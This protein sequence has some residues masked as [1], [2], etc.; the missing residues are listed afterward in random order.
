[1]HSIAPV[2]PILVFLALWGVFHKIQQSWR[3]GFLSAALLWG[4]LL[5]II[6]EILSLF[7]LITF[8]AICGTWGLCLALALVWWIKT[9]VR[10]ENPLKRF[11]S[12]GM[13]IFELLLL[14]GIAVIAGIVALIAWVAP[15]NTVDALT[16]HMSRV[17]HWTQDQSIAFYPTHILRQLYL[18]P[19]SE[20]AILHFQ[21]LSASDRLANFV[22]WFSMVGSAIGLSLIAKRFGADLRGQVFS[23]VISTTIPIGILQGS[24]T[25]NDHAVAFWLVCFIYWMLALKA[26]CNYSSALAS[27]A[28]LGLAALTKGTA[29][30]YALPFVLWLGSSI[31]KTCR[32]KWFQIIGIIA[33]A[34]LALNLGYYIRNYELFSSPLGIQQETPLGHYTITYKLSNDV[35]SIPELTSNVVRNAAMNIGTPIKTV[36]LFLEQAVYLLHKVIG[37]SANDPRTTWPEMEFHVTRILF[38]EDHDGNFLHFILIIATFF[39]IKFHLDHRKILAF[40]SLF[41]VAAFLLFSL[42]LKWQPW[43]SRLQLPLFVLWSPAIGTLI[44]G[45]QRKSVANATVIL[46]L[47]GSLPWAFLNRSRPLIGPQSILSTDRTELYFLNRPSLEGP[48]TRA[49][50]FLVQRTKYQ[51]RRIGL[52][53]DGNSPEYPFWVLLYQDIGRDVLIE[54]VNVE[55]VSNREYDE[56]PDFVPC[57]ILAVDTAPAPALEVDG[58]PYSLIWSVKQVYLFMPK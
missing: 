12:A 9:G 13:P 5:T 25:Q 7:K 16:Y 46:L 15:P 21:V 35:F 33:V 52:Y 55:N 41:L 48:Y 18:N 31:I 8:W 37:I 6:T 3:I 49:V 32:G 57:A 23:A 50:Q 10:L 56:F 22:Q 58:M 51:C 26:K 4:T 1:M 53:L 39:L 54:S 36:N 42:Y 17:M 19:W 38:D 30:I 47:L 29:Y 2:L 34:A 45:I 14:A 40:Y 28:G 27:G 24:S 44:S 43:N 11:N 20:F